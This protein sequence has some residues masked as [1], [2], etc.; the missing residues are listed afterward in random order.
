MGLSDRLEYAR[1][2]A[3]LTMHQVF[4]TTGIYESSLSV[5]ESGKREP[6][7]CQLQALAKAYN[8][9]IAF[10]LSD[11]PIPHQVILWRQRPEDGGKTI[12]ARFRRLCEQYRNLENWCGEVPPVRILEEENVADSSYGYSQARLLA[13]RVRKELSL[14]DR[15]AFGL[16]SMLEDVCGVKVFHQ[17]F[18]PTGSAACTLTEDFG[19][20][21]LLNSNN[22][23]R[24]RNYDLAHELFHLCVWKVFRPCKDLETGVADEMEEKLATCFAANLLMPEEAVRTAVDRRS[25]SGQLGYDALYDIAREFDVSA[26][27]LLWRFHFLW[28]RGPQGEQQTKAEIARAKEMAAVYETKERE[29]DPP[30]ERPERFKALA[31][32]ALSRGEISVGRFAEYMGISRAEAMEFA[33]Q[34]TRS[35]GEAWISVA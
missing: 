33:E 31:Q 13:S 26:E 6:K 21:I 16:L 5:F 25:R 12:E 2:Q 10:L 9:S 19:A 17:P 23:R 20:A 24:R 7:L 18:S 8:Q 1:K 29:P 32:K 22:P 14:G 34:E 30:E 35:S 3:G 11:E 27:S 15:P 4:S 28:G